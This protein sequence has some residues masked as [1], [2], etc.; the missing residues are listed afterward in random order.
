[1]NKEKNTKDMIGEKELWAGLN[2]PDISTEEA[3]VVVFGIPY[4]GAVSVRGGAK[5]APSTLRRY[6]Y[7]ITPTTEDFECFDDMKVLDLGDYTEDNQEVL[8]EKVKTQVANLARKGKFF[9]MLGGDHSVTIPV[10]QGLNQGLDGNFGIIHID[11]HFDL[12]DEMNGSKYS[13]GC[14]ARRGAELEKVGGSDNIFFLGIRSVEMDELKFMNENPV[15]VLNAR[16]ISQIGVEKTIEMVKEKMKGLDNIYITIDI[17]ALDPGYAAG[18]GTPQFGGLMGR[19]LL[20]IL[21]GL[22]DLPVIAFDVVEVAPNLDDSLSSVFAAR[23]IIT[24]CWGHFL[25]KSNRLK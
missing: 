6:S 12:C 4:D 5:E 25:R 8:F 7:S 14:P 21:R 22:F 2:C 1:M 20:E 3:D 15:N 23:K 9:T 18:T 13:H 24:E 17:D 11:A 10:Y 16:K 19:E